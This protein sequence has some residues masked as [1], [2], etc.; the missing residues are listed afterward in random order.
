MKKQKVTTT[1][2]LINNALKNTGKINLNKDFGKMAMPSMYAISDYI[3]GFGT[4]KEMRKWCV[5]QALQ[6]TIM[7]DDGMTV[8][9]DVIKTAQKIYDWVTK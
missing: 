1:S 4:V 9:P 2:D 3:P 6:V 5:E 8:Q 7:N